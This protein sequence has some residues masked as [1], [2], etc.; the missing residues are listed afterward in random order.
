M[1]GASQDQSL[2]NTD[3]KPKPLDIEQPEPTGSFKICETDK[4]KKDYL[5]QL[6]T[7]EV[8]KMGET[9]RTDFLEKHRISAEVR[10]RMVIFAFCRFFLFYRES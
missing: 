7:N 3:Q 2:N 6:M 1:F 5:H 8:A 4:I 9:F 10:V